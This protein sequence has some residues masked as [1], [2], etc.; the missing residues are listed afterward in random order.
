MHVLVLV[1]F[2]ELRHHAILVMTIKF[3]VHHAAF[4]SGSAF[5]FDFALVFFSAFFSINFTF[6]MWIGPSRSAILPWG[7]SC[8]LRRCFLIIRTPSISTRY[9]PGITSRILPEEPLKF[10]QITSTSSPFL[11]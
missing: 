5:V 2:A 11:T 3:V 9:L 4:F 10:P 7:L 8:D 1:P 6:E